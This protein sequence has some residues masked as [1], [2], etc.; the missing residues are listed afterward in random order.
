[1]RKRLMLGL[2]A[3]VLLLAVPLAVGLPPPQDRSLSDVWSALGGELQPSLD[4]PVIAPLLPGRASAAGSPV[5]TRWGR[6]SRPWPP[7]ATPPA[8]T[9]GSPPPT[10]EPGSSAST[11]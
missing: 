4:L 3:L 7:A 5:R 1:M 2:M 8:S 9:G 11:R 6:R 10:P